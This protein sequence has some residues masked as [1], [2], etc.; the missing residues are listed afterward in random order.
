MKKQLSTY[1]ELSSQWDDRKKRELLPEIITGHSV[2]H[3]E[4]KVCSS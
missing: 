1:E 4:V 2:I 3:H